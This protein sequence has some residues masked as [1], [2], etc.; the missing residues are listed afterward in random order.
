MTRPLD[1]EAERAAQQC[2][3]RFMEERYQATARDQPVQSISELACYKH[4]FLA[5]IS[6]QS[7]R[8]SESEKTLREALEALADHAG[9]T[10]CAV[11]D[12]HAAGCDELRAARAALDSVRRVSIVD[13]NR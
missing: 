1:Q 5:G 12:D 7:N 8:E 4:G 11:C 10:W 6:F 3:E 2:G 9:K 13:K